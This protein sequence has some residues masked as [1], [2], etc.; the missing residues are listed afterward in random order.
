[1]D[2][3]LTNNPKTESGAS[4]RCPVTGLPI[5]QRPEW[6]DVDF[7][8]D[9]SMTLRIVCG[10]ILHSRPSGYAT[11]RD[12][13][14]A[15]DLTAKVVAEAIGEG[16]PYVQIE[17][18]SNL[19]GA[20]FAG[21]KYFIDNM[22]KR[23][24]LA[25]LI[26][27]GAT[28]FLKM[29]IKL[30]KRFSIVKTPVELVD[31]YTEAVKLALKILSADKTVPVD[32]IEQISAKLPVRSQKGLSRD[33]WHV[34]LDGF[35]A[36]YELID[37]DIVHTAAMGSLEEAH[38]SPLFLAIDKSLDQM[39]L[40]GRPVYFVNGVEKLQVVT[41]KA[42]KLFTANLTKM[43]ENRPFKLLIFYGANRLFRAAVN[44]A[45]PF[46]P[47]RVRV[48]KDLDSA[49][50][51][52]SDE[53][54]GRTKS[55]TRRK[56]AVTSE[57]SPMSDQT[58]QYVDEL[59]HFIG[60][61]N[62]EA[63]GLDDNLIEKGSS[64][65]LVPVFDAISLIKMDI[66]QLF[67][68]RKRAGD[69]LRES[70]GKYR[71][72]LESIEEGYFEVD[73]AGNLTFFNPSMCKIAG[74][75][76]DELMG[77]N[78]R[79]FLDKENAEKVYQTSNTV[80]KT[81][82]PN[83]GFGFELIGKDGTRRYIETSVYLLTNAEDEPIGFRGILRDFTERKNAEEEKKRLK[84]QLQHAQRMEAVGSLAAGI[85]HNFNNLLMGIQGR[86]SLML[87]D[88]DSSSPYFEHLKGI[89]DY[90]KSAAD[91]TKQLLG[92]ARGGK[93][94]VKPTDLNRL[95]EK[96]SEMFGR[97][98][99]EITIYP[100]YQREIWSVAVDQG[101]VEQ[102]LLNLYVNAWQAMPGGG[103]LYVKTENVILDADDVRNYEMTPGRYVKI[104]IR[105]TGVGMDNATQQRI[106]DPFFTTREM[107]RG[108]GLGL[109]SAYGIIKNHGGFIDVYSKKGHGTTFNFYLPATQ[110]E[111]NA[112]RSERKKNREILRGSETVLLVDDEVLILETGRELLEN[113]GH[114][115]ILAQSGREAIETYAEN[116]ET[117]AMV[118]LDM[119][120]PHMGG[121]ETYHRLKEINPD[122][123]VLLS[124]GY[125]IEGQATQILA[126]GC[127][128]FIQKPF[129]IQDLSHKLREVLD[130]Q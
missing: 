129:N 44:L 96:S 6:T 18:Y 90:V 125:S 25:S 108:T 93:Y 104:S 114:K 42:R 127:D 17:D 116:R 94:E 30:G 117:I 27:C 19:H 8:Q 59:L 81:G 11:R 37:D 35:S 54:A 39:K 33:D 115:A 110:A 36:R 15:L 10:R 85:A 122:I 49:L 71:A 91:L 68:E 98:K 22:Q 109:A 20:A 78:F 101:Q 121:G 63:D 50:K 111:G 123:K 124:S 102:V 97:T 95:L 21:R 75:S 118:I 70:E 74:H 14:G 112:Q 26:F 92:F 69:A 38:I 82:K 57:P 120:M 1:M 41:R 31:N 72:V 28:P 13:E 77:K 62:W 61:I 73:L 88:A 46:V 34:Q 66:D 60:N 76:N 130:N 113:L 43:Y 58:S 107:S 100:E 4:S 67:Q 9:F 119:I 47:F 45:K 12:V 48:V 99:K 84:A 16:I 126:R 2:I 23:D 7:G 65:P 55:I 89:E 128:G 80:Y 5:L 56:S 3:S 103:E 40:A 106:F 64:H 86:A 24:Q 32:A 83:E 79:Q 52:I 53:K 29:S 51:L 105:D 87:M